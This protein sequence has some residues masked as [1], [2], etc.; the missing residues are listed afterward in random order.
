VIS[1]TQKTEAGRCHLLYCL[2]YK[3][4]L[5]NLERSCLKNKVRLKK[6]KNKNKNK[7][8]NKQKTETKM[9]S[10]SLAA[11]NLLL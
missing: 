1:I 8:T 2:V 3:A 4:S 11:Q 6:N 5:G 7:Q 9:P 10:C